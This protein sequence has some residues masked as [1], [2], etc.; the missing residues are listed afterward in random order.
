MVAIVE[1]SDDAI[2]TTIASKDSNG[3]IASWNSGAEKLFGYTAAEVIGKPVIILIPPDRINEETQILG[4]IKRLEQVFHYETVRR[5]K[6]GSE[7]DVS[8]TVLPVLD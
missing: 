2:V 6:D 8:L 1:S 3:I 7:I 5:R 4:G